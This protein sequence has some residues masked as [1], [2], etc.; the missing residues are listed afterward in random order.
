MGTVSPS[1]RRSKRQRLSLLLSTCRYCDK[2]ADTWDHAIP[3]SRGGPNA[4]TNLYPCCYKCNQDK[5]NLTHF[6]FSL[7]IAESL[8]DVHK[9]YIDELVRIY[10]APE[11]FK[12]KKKFI[13]LEYE[14]YRAGV[15][16]R[17]LAKL[18]HQDRPYRLRNKLR[19]Y[20]YGAE[21]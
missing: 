11:D 4:K 21:E 2:M 17:Q 13:E 3:K 18:F 9:A 7:K 16:I 12:A 15:S 20:G 19:R 5:G 8:E 6:E 10:P 1:T 14:A